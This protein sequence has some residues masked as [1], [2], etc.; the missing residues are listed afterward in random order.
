M[1]SP[2]VEGR[3]T[4][5]RI[6]ADA[7]VSTATVSKVLNGRAGVSP[8]TRE[9]VEDLLREH[10]YRRR[11]GHEPA[12][13]IELVIVGTVSPWS[14]EVIRGVQR[15]ARDTGLGVVVTAVEREDAD[16]GARD[17]V[18]DLLRRQVVG[19]VLAVPELDATQKHRLRSRDVPFVLMD[20]AGDPDPSVPMVGSANWTGGRLATEH[21][22]G[23]GHQRIGVI[24][25]PA[26]VISAQARLS[27]HRSA[28]DHARIA[29]DPDLI[30]VGDFEHDRGVELARE[31]L[32]LP[33]RPTAIFAC[34]DLMALGVYEAARQAGLSI[35]GDLSVIGFDDLPVAAWAGPPLTTV[36]QP[37]ID[38][39]SEAAR[40]V[41]ALR[42][43]DEVPA[44]RVDLACELIIRESTAPCAGRPS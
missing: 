42:R 24:T 43:G 14:A 16:D 40:L 35:P 23:L 15:I 7:E 9:R 27:G 33:E 31:L 22:L 32:A 21:L 30:V 38:M 10:G 17:W 4:L 39:G 13:L 1:P 20:P 37:L 34:S 19:A 44:V 2:V 26:G 41:L 36:R 6:A 11:N 3:A 25:G 29:Q 28:L 5:S 18:G 8:A 12:G